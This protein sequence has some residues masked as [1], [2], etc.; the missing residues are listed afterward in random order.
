MRFLLAKLKRLDWILLFI[1]LLFMGFSTMMIY[2]ATI[3]NQQ[4]GPQ[5]LYYDNIRNYVVGFIVMFMAAMFD[6]RWLQ[7]IVYALYGLGI[8]LLVGIFFFG[9]EINNAQGWY[10]LP[11]GL[12]FQPAEL[13]KLLLIIMIAHMLAKSKGETLST[14]REVVP[15]AIIVLIPFVLVLIQPDLGNAIIYLVI[16]LGMLWIGN[17]KYSHV[18][19]GLVIFIVALIASYNLYQAYHAEITE[20]FKAQGKGHWV[21]RIDTFLDPEQADPNAS[22]QLRKSMTAIGSGRFTG[23]GFL[24][25]N[26][27]HNNYIP[28]AYSDAIFVV[29]AEEFGFLGSSILLLIYF[30]MLYRMII[31]SIH[32]S[33]F[34]GSYMIIGIVSYFVFQI[35]E[36]IGMLLGIMPITGITLPFISYGGTSLIMNMLS[37]G[38]VMSIQIHRDKDQDLFDTA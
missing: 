4:F 38:I 35:F 10:K 2:S 27:V 11:A 6:Y 17:I 23:D 1:L 8:I 26:S 25:G 28:Y 34:F 31:A 20:F 14:L 7:K 24:Q 15:I 13:M 33:T 3:D 29:I 30:L 16:M 18:A 9:S 36:N 22:Y 19:I 21:K 12:S 5:R 37:I 32:S